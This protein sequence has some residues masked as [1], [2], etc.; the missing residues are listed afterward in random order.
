MEQLYANHLHLSSR[1]IAF[2][3]RLMPIFPYVILAFFAYFIVSEM[4]LNLIFFD[5]N[6]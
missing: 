1:M 2:L 3:Y 6:C 5:N 4:Q